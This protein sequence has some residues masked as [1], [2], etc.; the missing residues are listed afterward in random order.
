MSVVAFIAACDVQFKAAHLPILKIAMCELR[1]A[2][3]YSHRRSIRCS[4]SG[5]S[6]FVSGRSR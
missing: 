4:S 2:G 5:T 1:G 6:F 3:A